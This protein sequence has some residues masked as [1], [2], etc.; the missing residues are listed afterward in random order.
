MT[1]AAGARAGALGGARDDAPPDARPDAP[2]RLVLR[3][4]HLGEHSLLDTVFGGMSPRSRYLRFHGATPR[5]TTAVRRLLVAVDGRRHVAVVALVDGRAVGIA[6][7]LALGRGRAEL[8]VEVVDAWHGRGVGTALVRAVAR[9]A[10]GLGHTELVAEVLAENAAMLA[11]LR[12][13][14]PGH[15]GAREG[16]EITL[17]LPLRVA[18]R[19][20]PVD[21]LAC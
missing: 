2:H 14:F 5:L 19:D 6:R 4:V 1:A 20:V 8:A 10:V 21:S 3:E 16:D 15:T 17:R 11:L 9:R 13:E 7:C 12:R 18:D